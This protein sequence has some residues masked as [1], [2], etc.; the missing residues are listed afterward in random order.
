M[1]FGIR[2]LLTHKGGVHLLRHQLLVAFPNET[3]KMCGSTVCVLFGAWNDATLAAASWDDPFCSL[4]GG[5][6]FYL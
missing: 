3:E 5:S 1:V 4:V 6:I 2:E